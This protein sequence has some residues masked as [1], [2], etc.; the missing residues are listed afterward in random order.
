MKS[1]CIFSI[2][3]NAPDNVQFLR[4]IHAIRTGEYRCSIAVVHCRQLLFIVIRQMA[5]PNVHAMRT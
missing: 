4:V 1:K 5:E 3:K 2:I